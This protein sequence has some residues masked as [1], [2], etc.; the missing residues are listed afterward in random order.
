MDSLISR[1]QIHNESRAVPC[2][3]G[4]PHVIMGTLQPAHPSS[5]HAHTTCTHPPCGHLSALSVCHPQWDPGR[6]EVYTVLTSELGGIS[7]SLFP[8]EVWKGK[9]RFQVGTT[10]GLSDSSPCGESHIGR[11]SQGG[12]P[13]TQSRT[14]LIQIIYIYM[15]CGFTA[16]PEHL[17]LTPSNSLLARERSHTAASHRQPY[18][19]SP[20]SPP[21]G[22]PTSILLTSNLDSSNSASPL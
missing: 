15:V 4:P 1:K 3:T 14:T 22:S 7:G 21:P 19:F 13:C 2:T 18:I 17:P 10:T 16:A 8:C 6:E 9:H 5:F 11:G 20:Q 12:A